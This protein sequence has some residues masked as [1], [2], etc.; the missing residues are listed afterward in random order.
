MPELIALT[1]LGPRVCHNVCLVGEPNVL[2]YVGHFIAPMDLIIL[3][4]VITY[5][6]FKR[7]LLCNGPEIRCVLAGETGEIVY[8]M[9][10]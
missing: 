4:L 3:G 1:N 10:M 7:E 6:G 8:R 5:E 2:K 9:E